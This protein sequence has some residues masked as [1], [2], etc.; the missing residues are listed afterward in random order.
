MN[1]IPYPKIVFNNGS[2]FGKLLQEN[3]LVV[4]EMYDGE[5]EEAYNRLNEAFIF[6]LDHYLAKY[7]ILINA[8]SATMTSTL[9]LVE[10][11]LDYLHIMQYAVPRQEQY[12]KVGYL[13]A[14]KFI[15]L[16]HIDFGYIFNQRLKDLE[17]RT[18]VTE[19][20]PYSY[21]TKQWQLVGLD[22]DI[23]EIVIRMMG[24]KI[25]ATHM[26]I[27]QMKEIQELLY[28][29]KMDMYLTRRACN[30]MLKFPQVV[31]QDR[32]KVR[33]MMPKA[34][35][36]NFNLQFLKPYKQ[37]VWC[38]LLLLLT[39]A[40]TLN[41]IF[42]KRMTVNVMMVIIFGCNH[43]TSRLTAVLVVVIQFL[44]FILLEAYLGQVTSF[45]IRLRYQENPQTLGEFFDSSIQLNAP[46]IMKQFISH[47]PA[48][49]SSKMSEKLRKDIPFSDEA[50]FEPGYAYIVTEYASDM[51]KHAFSYDS[52]FNSTFF[53]IM[54]EPLYEFEM[55]YVFSLWSKFMRKYQE[56]LQRLYEAGIILK[57]TDVAWSL[58]TGALKANSSTVLMF[59]DL[60]PVFLFLCYGWA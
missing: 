16:D 40:C 10:Y 36:I 47:L 52:M 57:L 37:E 3:C 11:Y 19:S 23:V 5:T 30:P 43:T 9:S 33:L 55:C 50:G 38:L 32:S 18:I 58:A 8:D 4:M 2:G 12:G 25:S 26:D 20:K 56:C 46:E 54:E 53:Y 21:L 49:L 28:H 41:W 29:K 59:P 24:V 44:K 14:N 1:T 42:R 39:I 27:I 34:E 22:I 13:K 48:N 31:L 15:E 17:L 7:V 45:M 51:M 60:V 6:A 35:M